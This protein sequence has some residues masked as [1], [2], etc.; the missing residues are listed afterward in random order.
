MPNLSI[1]SVS[2]IVQLWQSLFQATI[3][4]STFGGSI[5]FQVIFQQVDGQPVEED[6]HV[7]RF[8]Y[9]DSRSFLAGSWAAFLIVLAISCIAA[10]ALTIRRQET[11]EGFKHTFPR[12]WALFI[13]VAG[14]LA[15]EGLIVAFFFSSLAVTAYSNKTGWA[16][17]GF[18]V[19][20]AIGTLVF[21]PALV[22]YVIQILCAP[23][24]RRDCFL[25]SRSPVKRG[26]GR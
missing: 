20:C 17:A 18:T 21:W 9:K 22:S 4:M 15:V 3:A 19:L 26:G 11:V 12:R 6:P 8:D 5:T 14:W 25:T 1:A 13:V 7:F 24:L 10:I 16:T 2:H 23:S